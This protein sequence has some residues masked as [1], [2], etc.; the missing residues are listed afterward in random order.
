MRLNLFL[1]QVEDDS[2]SEGDPGSDIEEIENGGVWT[3]DVT[4][5]RRNE[6]DDSDIDDVEEGQTGSS[7]GRARSDEEENTESEAPSRR[8]P[9]KHV[10]H[11]Q[12]LRYM[13]ARRNKSKVSFHLI[14]LNFQNALSCETKS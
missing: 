3:T 7:A 6:V 9:R 14:S 5:L 8:G 12:Y 1:L 2:E 4:E 10:S 11:L 13:L